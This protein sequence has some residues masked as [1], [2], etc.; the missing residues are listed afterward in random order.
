MK[1]FLPP[2]V[3]T[4]LIAGVMTTACS[5]NDK[6]DGPGIPKPGE[7]GVRITVVDNSIETRAYIGTEPTEA[8]ETQLASTLSV[9]VYD[10]NGAFEHQEAAL[11]LDPL[12]LK[13]DIFKVPDGEKY[14]YIF[15]N[16]Q[17]TPVSQAQNMVD[18]ETQKIQVDFDKNR[19]KPAADFD[20]MAIGTLWRGDHN[21]RGNLRNIEGNKYGG[22][23]V[24]IRLEVGR[25]VAKIRLVDIQKETVPGTSP[26]TGSFANAAYR[27]RSVPVEYYLVGQLDGSGNY[28]PT[29]GLRYFSAVHN[30]GPGT[31]GTPSD[32]FV[33]YFWGPDELTP[34][35][36][37]YY[38]AIENTT[39]KMTSENVNEEHLFYGNTTYIQFRIEYI[40]GS[41]EVYDHTATA[42]TTPQANGLGANADF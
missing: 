4:L 20:A 39:Q 3:A 34:S 29:T 42:P 2:S 21:E 6:T 36:T 41:N 1:K 40:T 9:Y 13:T 11:P 26:L 18:M 24:L 7:T 12:T 38:Y 23:P 19:P 28:P 16:G 17:T 32:K 14:F 35:P 22:E 15:S 10:K 30:I 37:T 5:D 27:L 8:G 33:D 31:S 25:A